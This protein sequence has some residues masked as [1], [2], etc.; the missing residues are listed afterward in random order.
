MGVLSAHDG[1]EF[2]DVEIKFSPPATDDY[3]FEVSSDQEI[4]DGH[5]AY[6]LAINKLPVQRLNYT[7]L[8]NSASIN[9]RA[10]NT[11]TYFVAVNGD[12]EAS[13]DIKAKKIRLP[14]ADS[15][16]ETVDDAVNYTLGNEISTQIDYEGDHDW[17]KV[18]LDP[19]LLYTSP[20]PRD[21]TRS[22]MPSSA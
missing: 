1:N 3:Y 20:S 7:E 13:Y 16:G 9:W 5:K 15:I 12:N 8:K 19:C 11:V 2:S 22:R 10:K 6:A 4:S 17:F 21:R 14:A 18:Q